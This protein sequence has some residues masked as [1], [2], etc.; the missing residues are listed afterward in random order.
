MSTPPMDPWTH[1]TPAYR[2]TLLLGMSATFLGVVVVVLAA[3]AVGPENE[4]TVRTIGLGLIGVGIISHLVSI[5]LRKRQAM[6]IIRSRADE[7][8][9]KRG[10]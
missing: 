2:R 4:T 10:R 9:K 5:L 3:V 1:G 7:S 6:Q 8:T